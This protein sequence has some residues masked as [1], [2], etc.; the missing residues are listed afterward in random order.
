MC[1]FPL[2]L[3][4]SPILIRADRFNADTGKSLWFGSYDKVPQL[5]ALD[6]KTHEI[7]HLGLPPLNQDAVA[8]L[9][10]NPVNA[11]EWAMATLKRDVYFSQ[12]EGK[13]WK[14]IAQAGQT[15]E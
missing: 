10:Q 15:L 11:Q 6:L 12:D 3:G 4:M 13:T 7:S 14:A 2:Y 5:S 8:Y 1:W 9:A